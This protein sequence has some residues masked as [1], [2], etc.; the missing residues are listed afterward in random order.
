M[1]P[2]AILFSGKRKARQTCEFWLA[3]AAQARR[4]AALA[5]AHDAGIL[6]RYAG[7][8]EARARG[9]IVAPPPMAQT[10]CVALLGTSQ[11]HLRPPS[12]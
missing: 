11:V 1:T 6:E 2:R 8:C 12:N 7:E 10:G 9:S 4:I 5:P 3:R